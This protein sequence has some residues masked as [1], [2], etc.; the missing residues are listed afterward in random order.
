M[1]GINKN[2][3]GDMDKYKGFD[4]KVFDI[5]SCRGINIQSKVEKDGTYHV[6]FLADAGREKVNEA[7]RMLET[8]GLKKI[9]FGGNLGDIIHHYTIKAII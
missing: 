6:I 5:C 3:I 4:D 7:I 8:L 2:D 1:N 9:S